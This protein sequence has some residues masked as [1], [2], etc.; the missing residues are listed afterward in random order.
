M[1]GITRRAFFTG[2][3]AIGAST[4]LPASQV[5]AAANA[6][7]PVDLYGPASGI[8]KLNANENP[9]GPSPM[10]IKAAM[11]ATKRGAYY[12]RKSV[13]KLKEMI[14]EE[15][16]LTTDHVMLS[17]GSSGV[18]T[19]IASSAS[20]KGQI[21]APDLF[22]D[23]T[24]RMGVRNSDNGITRLPKNDKLVIDLAAMDAS[25]D[26]S[27]SMVQVTNPNNPTGMAL[28][29]AALR[30]FCSKASEKT[31]VLVDEAYNELTDNP[32]EATMT[33]LIKEGKNVAV[34]R[35]FS[36]IYGL[37][38]MR[39]GYLLADPEIIKAA[40]NYG[41]GDYSLNQAGI[42]AALASYNDEK[43]LAYSKAKIVEGREM[44]TEALNANGLIGL[45]SQTNFMFVDLGDGNAE[46]FRQA[47]AKR[48]VLI[49]RIY[50]DYTNWSRVSMGKIEHVQM[51]VDALPAALEEIS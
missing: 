44:V 14:A 15:H 18:L 3:A 20:K 26:D 2:S 34:A 51:Y 49:Q 32:P 29:P 1:T 25:I 28:D 10:A 47:M 43:F 17:S 9:Y 38:G 13:V 6:M 7:M 41:L 22:W 16:G 50:R 23:T 36:K 46:A 21:L 12:A 33:P 39:V 24:A 45:P 42:A 37:A 30:A 5:I 27:V 48:N 11:E 35:T 8:A 4:L 31:M 40:T 19:Y